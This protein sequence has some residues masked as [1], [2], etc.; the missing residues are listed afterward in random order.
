MA[1][2]LDNSYYAATARPFPA[3]PLLKGE[4]QADVCVIGGG[5]TGLS[6]ALCCAEAGFD[7]ILI[8]AGVIGYGAS[9]RNG[10]QLIPGL[11][12]EAEHLAKML[13]EEDG[14]RLYK[15]AA[16]ARD[17][18]HNRIAKHE[19]D[20]D[21]RDGHFHIAAK[22]ADFE[23]M[24]RE[25]AYATDKLGATGLE[26]VPASGID[27]YVAV[28][29]YHGGILNQQGGHFHP[30][31]Y[32]RGLA[33][34]ATQA[35][36]RLFEHSRVI[37]VGDNTAPMVKTKEGGV[38]AKHIVLACDSFMEGLSR[39]IGSH[40]MPVLNYI[41]ATEPLGEE[42]ARSLIPSGAAISDSRFV[43][44]Y[45]RLS[46]DRRLLFAGGEKYTPNPTADIAAF[47]RP[48]MLKLF[49]QLS[50]IEIE[51]VWGGAV[52]ITMNRLPHFGRRDN[53][54]FAHGYSGQ[55]TLLTTLAG[56][57]IA[58]AIAGTA[59][60]FD[61]FGSIKHQKFPGGQLLRSPLYVAAMLYYA[62]RDRL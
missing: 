24:E 31:K 20:C 59:G 9:G 37:S 57:L 34:A 43:I 21:L 6:T 36:A 58:E 14:H 53:V 30:L 13:G 12:V 17:S 33:Q 45:F 7:T 5:F 54:F 35:G 61:L 10:G 18:V 46:A 28:E 38:K 1:A 26:L 60:R 22:K 48:Y 3:Q 49:P 2:S 50:D 4:H 51:Y 8:E 15:L 44:N 55:G 32:A 41:I 19:I 52:G 42:R 23:A 16:S 62:M 27:D 11:N 39:E 47:V 29:G 56:E 40:T 25:Y